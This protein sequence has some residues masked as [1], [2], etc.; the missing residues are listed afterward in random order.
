MLVLRLL[1]AVSLTQS[2]PPS[3]RCTVLESPGN[4]EAAAINEW[5]EVV[6][7]IP[8]P[9]GYAAAHWSADGLLTILPPPN[10]QGGYRA[11]DINSDGLIV[12]SGG[13]QQPI[14]VFWTLASGCH[15]L[16]WPSP[17]GALSVNDAGSVLLQDYPASPYAVLL[18][19]D[20]PPVQIDFMPGGGTAKALGEDGRVTGG[21]HNGTAL[22]AYR[23]NEQTGFEDLPLPPGC[24]SAFGIGMSPKGWVAGNCISNPNGI[25]AAVWNS[26]GQPQ[27]LWYPKMKIASATASAVN[28]SEWVVGSIIGWKFGQD[29]IGARSYAILWIGGAPYELSALVT[30]GALVQ[31]EDAFDINASGQI[32]GSTV[33]QGQSR[34]VR[35]DPLP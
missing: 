22:V 33:V 26:F 11:R 19:R 7:R 10:A 31:I 28:A 32:V 29:T 21:R 27:M 1:L 30:E 9:P 35:L 23:W 18:K 25:R 34:A 20:S 17:F 15:Q 5:G 14:P 24:Y 2:T 4:A 3:F 12:G 8:Q 13:D 6:G 16:P